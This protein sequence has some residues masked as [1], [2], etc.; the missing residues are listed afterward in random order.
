MPRICRLSPWDTDSGQ[1]ET[2]A[3]LGLLT[4]TLLSVHFHSCHDE[5]HLLRGMVETRTTSGWG[6]DDDACAVFRNGVFSHAIGQ[7]VY[8][9]EYD[10]TF[11]RYSKHEC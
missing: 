9:I 6:I 3:G 2:L 11:V 7:G 1:A 4:E 5:P 8:R 10:D